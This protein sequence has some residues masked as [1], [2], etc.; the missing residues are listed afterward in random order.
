VPV[1]SVR[2]R[3]GGYRL[4][5]G[6]RLPPLMFTDEEA[7]AV[8]LGLLGMR[9]AAPRPDTAVAVESATAK[10][11][12]VLPRA[13]ASRLD[14]LVAATTHADEGRDP[15]TPEAGVLLTVADAAVQRRPLIMTYRD[16]TERVLHPYGV[17]ALRGRWYATGLDSRSGEVRSFR[18]DR[19]ATAAVGEG[20]FSVPDGFDP[21]AQ[22]MEAVSGASYRHAV[23]VRVQ[24]DE[25]AVR[26][27]VPGLNAV[28]EP[29]DG[30]P[31]WVRVRWRAERLD[32]VPS[33][34]AGLGRPFIIEQPDELRERVCA[35]ARELVSWAEAR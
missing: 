25:Q 14:A 32:W 6:Y 21:A 16:R 2:G 29:A 7:L 18:L 22:V 4:A 9:H 23:S 27:R 26:M 17:V 35:L 30:E 13:L 20:Q 24:G 1:E 34:L 11:R 15:V 33:V 19:I 28:I 8:L 5:P 31:G 3:Y 10:I 12:R